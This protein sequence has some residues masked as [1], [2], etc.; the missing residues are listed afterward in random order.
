[1][2]WQED[3]VVRVLYTLFSEHV[4]HIQAADHPVIAVENQQVPGQVGNQQVFTEQVEV[5]GLLNVLV[6]DN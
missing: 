5:A 2:I 1:M 3:R 6:S 4:G